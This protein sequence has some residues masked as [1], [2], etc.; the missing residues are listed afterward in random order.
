MEIITKRHIKDWWEATAKE[1]LA[2]FDLLDQAKKL[3]DDKY[4]PNAYNIGM[5]LGKEAGQGIMH[6]HIHLIPRYRGDVENPL[7]GVRGIIP[8][9]QTYQKGF[10]Q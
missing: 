7:G 3:I 9:N 8:D 1:R 4:K 10:G 2:I 5:N 6:L